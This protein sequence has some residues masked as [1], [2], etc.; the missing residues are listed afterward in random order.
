MAFC[1]L[2]ALSSY[3]MII[4]GIALSVVFFFKFFVFIIRKFFS[5]TKKKYV[6]KRNKQTTLVQ[7]LLAK[8]KM[9]DQAN[10]ETNA[11]EISSIAIPT[12]K[13]EKVLEEI[14][15]KEEIATIQKEEITEEEIIASFKKQYYIV[16]ENQS[17]KT[18]S[19]SMEENSNVP[20]L[21]QKKNELAEKEFY[22][23]PVNK[24]DV[25]EETNPVKRKHEPKYTYISQYEIETFARECNAYVEREERKEHQEQMDTKIAE[26]SEEK[27]SM[28]AQYE[29]VLFSESINTHEIIGSRRDYMRDDYTIEPI[30]YESH[31]YLY[32]IWKASSDLKEVLGV[33][34][35]FEAME[36]I[37]KSLEEISKYSYS[38]FNPEKEKEYYYLKKN[39]V[40]V[41]FLNRSFTEEYNNSLEL[42]TSQGKI[43]RIG[44]WFSTV[45]CYKDILTPNAKEIF[46]SLVDIWQFEILPSILE[47]ENAKEI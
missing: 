13:T 21:E 10:E 47:P 23:S 41:E 28:Q 6:E 26:S 19:G 43:N 4:G 12:N 35:F 39:E 46:E 44:A 32:R 25:K 22:K 31:Q 5:Y 42:K 24:A 11:E 9:D 29:Y 16:E 3:G 34:K 2:I 45:Y 18:D 36:E 20:K 27:E 8:L 15:G 38:K 14:R 33:K 7:K 1:F 37:E 40:L 17:V 30:F